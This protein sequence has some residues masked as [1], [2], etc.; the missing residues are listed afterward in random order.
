MV[1]IPPEIKGVEWKPKIVGVFWCDK[2]QYITQDGI[3]FEIITPETWI[4][5]GTLVEYESVRNYCPKYTSPEAC[6][7]ATTLD[8]TCFWC[9]K[10]NICIDDT[11]QD[12]HNMKVNNCRV[13]NPEVNEM[14]TQTPTKHIE[15]T[16]SAGE[17]PV[18]N[19]PKETT[20]ETDEH[21]NMTTEI[22]KE[23]LEKE[24][25]LYITLLDEARTLVNSTKDLIAL[26]ENMQQI[27]TLQEWLIEKKELVEEYD[28]AGKL[29]NMSSLVPYKVFVSKQYTQH[30]VL[31]SEIE[32]NN[33][34]I[35]QVFQNVV[36]TIVQYP[37]IAD[38]L[39]ESLGNLVILWEN[40]RKLI[41]ERGDYMVQLHRAI[42]FEDGYNE[43]NRWLDKFFIEFL[44]FK[45]FDQLKQFEEHAEQDPSMMVESFIEQFTSEYNHNMK[46]IEG[47]TESSSN[48][49]EYLIENKFM[50]QNW[51]NKANIPGC[52]SMNEVSSYLNKMIK[53][54]INIDVKKKL[55]VEL[56]CS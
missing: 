11:D 39:S 25:P 13:E 43:L 48:I 49:L 8:I 22:T 3:E 19:S 42:I 16:S 27:E 6:Q 38:Q 46:M 50:N 33:D 36:N 7:N 2:I 54:L 20:E 32:S 1:N 12:A 44:S 35:E 47:T 52:S 14:S 41:R 17:F 34:R 53:C 37:R 4:N 23:N 40:L 30:R 51:T 9:D 21:L 55:L 28:Q 15:T 10:A 5:S 56:H 18:T 26:R 24:S 45:S 31:E 29:S